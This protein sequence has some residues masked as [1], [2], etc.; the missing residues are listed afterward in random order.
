MELVM[1]SLDIPCR[2]GDSVTIECEKGGLDPMYM[3][4]FNGGNFNVASVFLTQ[5]QAEQ[6][7]QFLIENF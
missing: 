4:I 5:T 1:A 6:L 7:K 2:F 3:R